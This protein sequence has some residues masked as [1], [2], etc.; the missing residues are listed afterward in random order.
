M[1]HFWKLTYGRVILVPSCSFHPALKIILFFILQLPNIYF[2]CCDL[3]L[4]IKILTRSGGGREP[5]GSLRWALVPI[6]QNHGVD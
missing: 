2:P 5:Y 3:L 1:L 6:R 4:I